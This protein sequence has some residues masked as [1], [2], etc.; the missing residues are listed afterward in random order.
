MVFSFRGDKICR[1][2]ESYDEATA[3]RELPGSP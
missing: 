1:Y 2:F 3:R